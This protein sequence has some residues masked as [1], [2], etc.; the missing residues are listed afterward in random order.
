VLSQAPAPSFSFT[1]YRPD[2]ACV[3]R[4]PAS[5]LGGLYL[6]GRCR[7][8][9]QLL[10]SIIIVAWLVGRFLQIFPPS[11][12]ALSSC[13]AELD[14]FF[15]AA[16]WLEFLRRIA[17]FMGID[18]H[19]PTAGDADSAPAIAVLKKR[20][21]SGHSEYSDARHFRKWCTSVAHI[22]QSADAV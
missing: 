1:W 20:G 8:A 3:A 21:R 2:V 11:T 13:E 16:H 5:L 10:S 12:V 9:Q 4:H 15:E 22:T 14:G 17:A 6:L 18:Q 7:H 19:G